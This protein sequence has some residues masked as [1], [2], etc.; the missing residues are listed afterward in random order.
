MRKL[1]LLLCL[2]FAAQTL[3]A[4]SSVRGFAIVVDSASYAQARTQI[5]AYAAEIERGG[6]KVYTLIDRWG[7]PDSLR[8]QLIA[9]HADRKAPIEGA[10]FIGDIPIPMIR[11]AQ[12]LTSAFKMNQKTF[13]KKESSVPS[14]RFYD[15]F[16]LEF[17]FLERDEDIEDYF[18]YSLTET[19]AQRLRPDIYTG[20][21]R[22]TDC[23]GT[24]RYERL[25]A[26][27]EK[28]VAEKRSGNTLDQLLYFSGHGFISESMMAR[29]DEKAML[30]DHFPWLKGQKNG[31]SYIDHSQQDYIKFPLMN[32]M[33]RE[34]LDYAVLHHH[35]DWDTQY[36]NNLPLNNYAEK[37][38]ASVKLYLR[39][40]MRHAAEHGKNLDTIKVKLMNKFDVPEHWF[41]GAFDA[42]QR[43]KD[44][45]HLYN[46]DLFL[47]D[48]DNYRPSARLVVLDACFNGSF[49]KDNSIANAYIFNEGK[50]IAVAANS[51]NVLQDKWID[52]YVGLV[53][54]GMRVG[55]LVK[56]G[57]YLEAHIIGD[58]TFAFA[59]SV[60]NFDLNDALASGNMKVWRKAMK[61][62]YPTV[63]TM[64]IEQLFRASELSSDDLLEIFRTSDCGIVR[65]QALV[66]LSECRDDNFVQAL[67]LSI[68]DSYEMVER[69][70]M[71]MIATCGDERLIPALISAAIRNN[72]TERIEFG[73]KQ[74]LPMY[75]TEKL[76]AEFE[77]Q[78]DE[79]TNYMDSPKVKR[80]IAH[81]IDVNSKRWIKDMEQIMAPDAK[82]TSRENNIRA[83]RNY[84]VHHMVPE[85][86]DYMQN[87]GDEQTQMDMLEAFGWFRLS[88]RAPEIA[89]V[90]EA[91]SRDESYPASVRK[92]ALKTYNRLK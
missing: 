59:P 8:A 13:D 52:R 86:L 5:E 4:A 53:G 57:P 81:A 10:V 68:G 73:V 17:R 24:S 72:T 48:F 90:A 31:I 1:N 64:A 44:S 87:C 88:Y 22:P 19:S 41:D 34:D 18:Y 55:N 79:S 75:D 65:V 61:S 56:Y 28:V 26:Y 25:R 77:R 71:N 70:G 82:P 36:L 11:D 40:S 69:F 92:E 54:M 6:L 80:Q 20:R 60:E 91:M 66:N 3:F 78:Y 29:I 51:V 49:H 76:L 16:S 47:S 74:A 89:A 84:H 42:A 38:I 27:L 85:L 67:S 58:P 21:I 30:L 33:Q 2:L 23:G 46:L 15:D 14:D 32:E 45:I 35:G 37:E 83:M 12:H 62:P 9:L 63:R 39:E 43:A 50:T 7:V